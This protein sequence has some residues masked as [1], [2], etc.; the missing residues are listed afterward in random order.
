M[1]CPVRAKEA[2]LT[3]KVAAHWS[4]VKDIRNQVRLGFAGDQYLCLSESLINW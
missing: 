4:G 2:K 3:R 1:V